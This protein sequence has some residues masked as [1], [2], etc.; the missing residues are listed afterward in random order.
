MRIKFQALKKPK[1]E[2]DESCPPS[3][4]ISMQLFSKW[5]LPE[6]YF[7]IGNK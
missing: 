2:C 1:D 6:E 7:N 3:A 4:D 5:S